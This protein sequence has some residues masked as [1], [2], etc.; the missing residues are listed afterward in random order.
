MQSPI[1]AKVD[2]VVMGVVTDVVL[3]QSQLLDVVEE[4]LVV[5]INS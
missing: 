2:G 5:K 4:I 1:I 3:L